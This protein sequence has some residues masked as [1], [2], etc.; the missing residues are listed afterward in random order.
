LKINGSSN[1][2]SFLSERKG[3]VILKTNH[4][5]TKNC[6]KMKKLSNSLFT[7]YGK[8]DMESFSAA[9]NETGACGAMES[10]VKN[11]TAAELWNIQRHGKTRAHRRFLL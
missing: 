2:H 11:F 9:I 10:P 3:K 8:Q 4:S 1:W 5:K 6:T 7:L